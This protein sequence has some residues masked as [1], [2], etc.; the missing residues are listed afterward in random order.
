MYSKT[1]T[2]LI[3]LSYILTPLM[4]IKNSDDAFRLFFDLGYKLP[5]RSFFQNGL[6]DLLNHNLEELI[7]KVKDIQK[8]T[9]QDEYLHLLKEL[10]EITE[11]LIT[12]ITKKDGIRSEIKKE[13]IGNANF[14]EK[15]MIHS[16]EFVRR[17]LDYLLFIYLYRRYPRIFSIFYLIGIIDQKVFISSG[18]WEPVDVGY[19]YIV[20]RINWESFLD[21]FLETNA[22]FDTVYSWNTEFDGDKFLH[23]LEF[24]LRAF[25]IPGGIYK[26]TKETREYFGCDIGSEEI[27]IPLYQDGAWPDNYKEFDLNLCPIPSKDNDKAGLAVYPY[28][29]GNFEKEFDLNDNLTLK[30][31][32]K[33]DMDKGL[34]LYIRPPTKLYMGKQ[35]FNTPEECI[36]AHF[37]VEIRKKT[38]EENLSYI[39]G[40]DAGSCLGYGEIGG[41]LFLAL[42]NGKEKIAAELL[43]NDLTLKIDMSEGDGFLQKILSGINVE[44]VTDLVIGIS[45]EDGFYFRGSGGLEIDIPLHISIGPISVQSLYIRFAI[46]DDK[47]MELKFAASLG[48]ALGPITGSVNKLGLKMPFSITE[49]N[50]GNFGPVDISPKSFVPP[51]G[52]GMSLNAGVIIGGGYLDFDDEN[53][54]YAGILTLKFGGIALVAIGLLTTRM[55]DGSKGFSL[56]VNIGVTFF[57]PIQLSYG[58]TLNAVGGLIGIN[59]TMVTE[60]LQAGIKTQTLDSILFPDPDTVIMNA[61][62]I[63]SDLRSVFPPNPGRFVVGPM[64]KIGWG[65][66]PIITGAVGIFI[67]LPDPV[68]I[69]LLGQV[70]VVLPIKEKAVIEIHLDII[71]ILDLEKGELSFQASLYNSRLLVVE[72]YGDAAMLLGWKNEPKFALSMGGFHPQYTPPQPASIFSNMKRLSVVLNKGNTLRLTCAAYQAITPNTLQFGAHVDCYLSVAGAKVTG[73]L[74]FDALLIFSPFSFIADMGG[75]VSIRYKGFKLADIHLNCTLSGPNPWNV[76]GNAKFKIHFVTIKK[77]F[78][79]SWGDSEK[80]TITTK[81]PYKELINAIGHSGS[82]SSKLPPSSNIVA[83]LR[84]IENE[85]SD[86]VIVHPSGRLEL[87]QNILPLCVA[88]DKI[89][90][91]PIIKHDKFE[92]DR[93]SLKNAED[94]DETL[95][96]KDLYEYFSRG[97]YQEL[98]NNEKLG[99]ASFQKMIAGVE[100]ESDDFEI[101]GEIEEAS[102]EYETILIDSDRS[103]KRMGYGFMK[104]EECSVINQSLSQKRISQGMLFNKFTHPDR[105]P[106][107]STY[108]DEKYFIVNANDLT[109]SETPSLESS[110][111]RGLL[112]T[113]IDEIIQQQNHLSPVLAAEM[114][115]VAEYERVQ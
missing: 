85:K 39:F 80:R 84:S 16:S 67:E 111:E 91:A 12:I 26:Q 94:K 1:E 71:G 65:T 102:L 99:L 54:R 38:P 14:L 36:D 63:I 98:S 8:L 5:G 34:V 47:K 97:Q 24:L 10:K 18:D 27:R 48:F 86:T 45:N 41:N 109:F 57:P 95:E 105:G 82:W 3:E 114:V 28:L 31:N 59:R 11:S 2:I 60:V 83:T 58:F 90:N 43:V 52:A 112:R 55:P 89:G 104:V 78:N 9:E 103:T 35:L 93:I 15:S 107:I 17:L 72:M 22:L 56:L 113:E 23:R 79:I 69:A 49:K 6:S 53:K 73:K 101:Y 4:R 61:P 115:L 40:P 100:T 46:S 81:D 30:L 51:T 77:S 29:I 44:T 25:L 33:I 108:G 50:T 19:K 92:I 88:L 20:K 68:R 13:L 76:K 96:F 7:S 42:D 62:K 32:V 87:R 106:M 21:F 64:I 37:E 74:G 66:P 70:E 75:G 110:D